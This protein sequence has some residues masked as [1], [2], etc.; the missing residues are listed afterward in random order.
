[1]KVVH[2]AVSDG[3][4]AGMG[5]MNQHHALL[6]LGVDSRVVVA[7]KTSSDPTVAEMRPN[8]NLWGGNRVAGFVQKALRRAGITFNDYDRWHHRIYKSQRRQ[9]VQFSQPCSQYDVLS[10]PL[11]ADADIVNLHY[12]SEFVDL[13]SFFAGINKPVVWTM[14]DENPG[15]GGFHYQ[16]IKQHYYQAFA[17]IEDAF[18]GVKRAAIGSCR[19]LHIVSLS[20]EMRQFCQGV[21]FL[22][23]KPNVKIYN[24]I[25]PDD[26]QP[27]G[28]AEARRQLGLAADDVV[29]AFV[30][31]HL[32]EGRKGFQLVREAIRLLGDDR[33]KLLCVGRCDEA[34]EEPGIITLDTVADRRRLSAVYSAADAF[35]NASSQ[36]SFGKTVVEALYC[37][38]PVVSTPTGIAPEIINQKNGRLCSERTPEAIAAAI[39]EVLA[40][41]YDAQA[42]RRDAVGKFAPDAVAKQYLNLYNSLSFILR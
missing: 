8:R 33:V 40:S 21:D 14:R 28:R 41:S 19:N 17:P 6:A 13:P 5:M 27:I 38:T 20:D 26:Y 32:G 29:L 12:V 34:I 3:G 36:E 22:S 7:R 25:S 24:A 16:S 35:V 42:I 1:M 4:G 15:L 2:I 18:V 23:D 10:H 11:V 31:C 39:A 30:S 9:S 37:G